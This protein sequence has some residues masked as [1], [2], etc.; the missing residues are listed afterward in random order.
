VILWLRP[1]LPPRRPQAICAATKRLWRNRVVTRH[2]SIPTRHGANSHHRART[3]NGVKTQL[4]PGSLQGCISFEKTFPPP[5]PVAPSAHAQLPAPRQHASHH[6]MQYRFSDPLFMG[7]QF[8]LSESQSFQ[9]RFLF[10][11]FHWFRW[12][13]RGRRP[14][15]RSQNCLYCHFEGFVI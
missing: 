5:K 6:L 11:P 12:V 15:S 13:V 14:I 9:N 2:G 3:R 1:P 4:K 8:A 7:G 10:F